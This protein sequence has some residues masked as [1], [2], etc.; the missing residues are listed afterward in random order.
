MTQPTEAVGGEPVA[1]VEAEAANPFETMA[2]EFLGPD[3]PEEEEITEELS[4][5]EADEAKA[6]EDET[7]ALE[8]EEDLP[9]IDAP[10]SWD[11]DAKEEF[12]KLPRALQETVQKREAERERFVQAKSQEAA[13]AQRNANI[14]AMKAAEAIKA[15]AIETLQRYEKQFEV[16]P[17]NPDLIVTDPVAYAQQMRA[18]QNIA[19]QREQAQR[20]AERLRTE[21]AQIQQARQAHEAEAFHQRLQ[22]EVPEVFDPA[23]GQDVLKELTATA[24]LLGFDPH[25]ISDVTAIKALKL[26]SEWKSK[27]EKYD[28]LIKKQ[29]ERVRSGKNPPP[30]AKP[31]TARLPEQTRKARGDAAWNQALNAKTRSQ[32]DAAIEAWADSSG[33]FD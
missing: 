8:A 29:M 9:S 18:Y 19:A 15:Q 7:E 3:E 20:D 11:G 25:Q 21:Q 31:G 24:E 33:F 17:P 13:Q 22:A 32:R 5:A 12:K 2:E 27:A 23:T 10:N 30:I 4:E 16:Q 28:S 1:P 14:E 26:T 6:E